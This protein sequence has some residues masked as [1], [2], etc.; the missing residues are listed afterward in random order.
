[1]TVEPTE[2]PLRADAERNR[3]RLLDAARLLLAERGLE[4]SMDDI[5]RAAGVGVGTAYR[6]FRNRDEIVDALFDEQLA[7][8]EAR[9]QAAAA[10]PDP[11]EGLKGFM[12]DS[13]RAQAANRG[14]KQL[15]FSSAQGREKVMRMRDRN[16]PLLEEVVTRAKEA[17]AVRAD[18]QM[19]DIAVMSFMVGAVVDFAG[20][21]DEHLWERY[22]TLLL[23]GL[24]PGSTSPLPRDGLTRE[25]LDEAMQCWRPFRR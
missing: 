3:R 11:W 5:A 12:V 6:R 22:F 7:G 19:T 1:M 15:L 8:M 9:A 10:H 18:L 4:V 13:L 20:A 2:R 16:G 24:R 25:Q 17:G 23:D 14:L 21:I